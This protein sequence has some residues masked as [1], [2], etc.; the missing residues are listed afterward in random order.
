M[1]VVPL[2]VESAEEAFQHDAALA[3]P[4][5]A[6]F[7]R[8]WAKAVLNRVLKSLE[9]EYRELD[10]V[11]RFEAMKPMLGLGA[12]GSMLSEKAELL[13]MAPGAFRTALHRFRARYRELFRIE[14]ASQVND[15]RDVD[16]EI[17]H[18]IAALGRDGG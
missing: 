6:L 2:E 16:D 17:R 14:V 1:E 11:A 8:K 15:P 18:L 13:G 10:Q 7:D 5:E 3:M 9:H 12:D 4:Q